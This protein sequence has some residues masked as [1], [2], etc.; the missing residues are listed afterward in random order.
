MQAWTGIEGPYTQCLKESNHILEDED[1]M[2]W[3]QQRQ[4][5]DC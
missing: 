3:F 2:S 4:G 5:G 1:E